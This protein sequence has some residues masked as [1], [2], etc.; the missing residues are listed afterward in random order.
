MNTKKSD[1]SSNKKDT[2]KILNAGIPESKYLLDEMIGER[3]KGWMEKELARH[4]G[5]KPAYISHMAQ[6]RRD[7]GTK[8]T[9]F[10]KVF[11]A[12]MKVNPEQPGILCQEQARRLMKC[13]GLT[14][15]EIAEVIKDEDAGLSSL[16]EY[17]TDKQLAEGNCFRIRSRLEDLMQRLK[18]DLIGDTQELMEE[19]EEITEYLSQQLNILFSD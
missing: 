11:K 13:C 15:K 18:D 6:G 10:K 4:A 1:P 19:L 3:G 5:T 17:L 8:P 2:L 16:P 14:D 7:Y 9:V 12:I